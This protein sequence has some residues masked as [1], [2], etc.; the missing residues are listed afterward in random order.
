[1]S[2][3]IAIPVIDTNDIEPT[4]DITPVITRLMLLLSRLKNAC[5]IPSIYVMLIIASVT[6][7][8]ME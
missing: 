2:F 4:P 8:L 5:I 1:M 6:Q 7:M 3:P